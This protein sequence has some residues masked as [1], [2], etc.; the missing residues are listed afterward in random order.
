MVKKLFQ[1]MQKKPK[2]E[3]DR[4]VEKS[5]I[6]THLLF[7]KTFSRRQ[8]EQMNGNTRRQE[9]QMSG[10]NG[11]QNKNKNEKKKKIT[12]H[13]NQYKKLVKDDMNKNNGTMYYDTFI[14]TNI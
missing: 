5:L 6:D 10:N 12:K 11:K 8:E 1:H 2:A 3:H 4:A 7:L 13:N 14:I 9:E